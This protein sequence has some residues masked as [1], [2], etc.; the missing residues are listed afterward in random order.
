MRSTDHLTITGKPLFSRM[1][2]AASPLVLAIAISAC[3]NGGQRAAQQNSVVERQTLYRE[4][5]TLEQ[6]QT[7]LPSNGSDAFP[8]S[9][10]EQIR[11]QQLETPATFEMLRNR[12][13]LADQMDFLAQHVNA[14]SRWKAA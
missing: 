14:N 11:N 6:S 5:N 10:Q 4:L 7:A 2:C 3:G 12:R 9:F 1:A 8:P 13:I